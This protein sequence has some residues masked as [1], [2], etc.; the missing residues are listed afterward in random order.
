ML[1]YCNIF[2]HI[3]VTGVCRSPCFTNHRYKVS[4]SKNL[5][6]DWAGEIATTNKPQ[7]WWKQSGV[8]SYKYLPPAQNVDNHLK[9]GTL[10]LR[11]QHNNFQEIGNNCKRCWRGN[12]RLHSQKYWFS[13]LYGY[14][15]IMP[16][17]ELRVI[18]KTYVVWWKLMAILPRR[19]VHIQIPNLY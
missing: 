6:S 3:V 2:N 19:A 9:A 10:F 11:M 5:S 1:S 4:I 7:S 13:L 18:R 16:C 12:V 17:P 8:H 14:L 15:H